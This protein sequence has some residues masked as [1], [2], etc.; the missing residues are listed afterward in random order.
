MIPPRPQMKVADDANQD[1]IARAHAA[2]TGQAPPQAASNGAVAKLKQAL[3]QAQEA[4]RELEG[5]EVSEGEADDTGSP[6]A[7]GAA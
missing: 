4:L 6:S 5:A 3:Q 1:R 7:Q 2:M